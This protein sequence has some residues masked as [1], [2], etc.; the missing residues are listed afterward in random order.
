MPGSRKYFGQPPFDFTGLLIFLSR[1]SSRDMASP[2]DMG[3]RA[4]SM[5]RLEASDMVVKIGRGFMIMKW[6]NIDIILC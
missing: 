3:R 1:D 2:T 5:I 4:A 6:L